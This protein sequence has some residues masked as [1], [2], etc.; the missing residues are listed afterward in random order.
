MTNP[1]LPEGHG[2]PLSALRGV[3]G[4]RMVAVRYLLSSGAQWPD[5]RVV[6]SVHE[7]DHGVE[8]VMADG[9][10][11]ALHWEMQEYDEFLAIAPMSVAGSLGPEGL[12]DALSVSAAPEWVGILGRTITGVGVAWHIP[13]AGCP[14]S[15][16]AA[17]I[18]LDGGSSFVIALGEIQEGAPTYHPTSI[19]ILF[20]QAVAASYRIPASTTSAWGETVPT[21]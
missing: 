3:V 2:E 5:V 10:V 21:S 8:L 11:L 19:V 20:D 12:I 15:V 18:D 9:S 7:V 16:W 1:P 4:S 6:G 14:R 17:R 13:N